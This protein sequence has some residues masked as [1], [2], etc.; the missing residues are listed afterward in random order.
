MEYYR[1]VKSELV[2]KYQILMLEKPEVAKGYVT[3]DMKFKNM[4]NKI[5]SGI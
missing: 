3:T 4:K 5:A 1:A 2:G